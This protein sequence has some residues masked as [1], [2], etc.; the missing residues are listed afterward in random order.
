MATTYTHNRFG[1][2]ALEKMVTELRQPAQKYQD[3]YLI[4]AQGPDLLFYYHVLKE[5][6]IRRQGSRIHQRSAENFFSRARESLQKADLLEDDRAL[7]Y[8]A[9]LLTHFLLDTGV[10]SYIEVKEEISACSHNKIEAE[11]DAYLMRL[12]GIEEP[13]FF[14]RAEL[15]IPQ[16]DDI[17]SI[18]GHYYRRSAK[19][20]KDCIKGQRR[21]LSLFASKGLKRKI[22][23]GLIKKK[24]PK[25]ADLF[26]QNEES[27]LCKDSNIRLSRI[28]Y[29]Q[30][31]L[32]EEYSRELADFM[33]KEGEL[34]GFFNRTFGVNAE[35][36]PISILSPQEEMDLALAEGLIL[37]EMPEAEES[38]LEES[39][40]EP[41]SQTEPEGQEE[42]ESQDHKPDE[43]KGESHD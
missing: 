20:I 24:M 21:L 32:V 5:N 12:D 23:Y 25:V 6:G 28:F 37:P 2:M 11:W 22:S 18:I 10:H 15:V 29:K 16:N 38:K 8:A 40:A 7:A 35:D 1:K 33:L 9:G 14:N 42:S 19:K 30:L 4:G 26:C 13:A 43:Q 34:S 27:P 3:L 17:Y 41:E 36:M 39:G 31:D